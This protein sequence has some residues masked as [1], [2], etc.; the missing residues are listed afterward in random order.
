MCIGDVRNGNS[1]PAFLLRESYRENGKIKTRTLSQPHLLACRPPRGLRQL[2]RG[3]FDNRASVSD[4]EPVPSPIF[5]LLFVLKQIADA[6]GTATGQHGVWSGLFLILARLTHQGS[7][8]SAVRSAED[9]AT[10]EVL[11]PRFV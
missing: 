3:V 1:P 2:L 9:H 7:R 4:S 6:L 5:G 8:L 11:G 10:S